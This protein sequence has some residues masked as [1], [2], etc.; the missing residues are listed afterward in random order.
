MARQK[1]AVHA[2]TPAVASLV[3]DQIRGRFSIYHVGVLA[4][5]PGTGTDV[6][7]DELTDDGVRALLP[8]M[9]ARV[10]SLPLD[11]FSSLLESR[12]MWLKDAGKHAREQLAEMKE[13]SFAVALNDS[14]PA[15]TGDRDIV[16]VAVKRYNS[17][18]IV[19]SSSAVARVKALLEEL[20]GAGGDGEDGYDSLE[21]GCDR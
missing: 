19:S 21:D 6:V 12:K 10:L 4:L 8:K 14:E 1:R 9:D 20:N 16:L 11:E 2:V 18:S 17:C 5:R 15:Q 3:T 13:C 7:S